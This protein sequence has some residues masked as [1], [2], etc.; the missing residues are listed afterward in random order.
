MRTT[1]DQFNADGILQNGFDYQNQAWVVNGKY[2]ACGHPASMECDCFGRLHAGEPVEINNS[3]AHRDQIV[4]VDWAERFPEETATQIAMRQSTI[5]LCGQ[6]KEIGKTS[7]MR[8][9]C[10]Q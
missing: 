4:F 9:G 10:A 8:V 5:C 6:S 2:V 3:T 7:C 1:A